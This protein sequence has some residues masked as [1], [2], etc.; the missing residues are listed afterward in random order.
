MNQSIYLSIYLPT[1][2]SIYLSTHMCIYM[3]WQHPLSQDLFAG[4]PEPL[5]ASEAGDPLEA[6]LSGDIPYIAGGYWG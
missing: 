4:G 2:L 5:Q 1:Y 6:N 3:L